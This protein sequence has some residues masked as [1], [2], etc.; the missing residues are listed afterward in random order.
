[1]GRRPS[2]KTPAVK[3]KAAAR[4]AP[5]KSTSAPMEHA[6]GYL[7]TSVILDEPIDRWLQ[8]LGVLCKSSGGKKLR[9]TTIIRAV[10]RAL[11]RLDTLDV[12]GVGDED[13]LRDRIVEAIRLQR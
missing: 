8:D 12:S 10:I 9:K 13:E 5:R 1:M 11:M 6:T 4:P 3:K 2:K 7:R